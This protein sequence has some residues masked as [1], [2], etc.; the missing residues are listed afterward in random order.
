M[1]GLGAADVEMVGLA[2]L[3]LAS[4]LVRYAEAGRMTIDE[5]AAGLVLVSTDAGPGIADVAQAMT[6]GFSTGGGLGFGLP[7]VRRLMDAFTIASD[8][9]GTRIRACKWRRTP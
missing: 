3:E 4:N 1:I 8:P 6:D 7:A 5:D 2:T 9:A